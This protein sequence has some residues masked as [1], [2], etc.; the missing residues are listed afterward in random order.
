MAS[1]YM[2][3]EIDGNGIKEEAEFKDIS[4]LIKWAL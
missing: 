2:H 3:I 1:G 4:T